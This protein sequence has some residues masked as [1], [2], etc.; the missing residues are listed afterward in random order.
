MCS[1]HSEQT[2]LSHYIAISLMGHERERK[3]EKIARTTE[4]ESPQITV[5]VIVFRKRKREHHSPALN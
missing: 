5:D 1:V 2:M 3:R 4:E